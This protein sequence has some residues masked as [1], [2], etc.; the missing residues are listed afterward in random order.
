VGDV[1]HEEGAD[2]LGHLGEAGEVDPE[3]VAEAPAMMSLGFVS[4]ASRS[5]CVVVDLFLGRE[6]VAHDLEPLA[7]HVERHAVGQVAAF[8]RLMP[9]IVSPG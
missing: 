1:D 3:A 2:V 6:A 7:A 5:I 4:C 9:M 8:G